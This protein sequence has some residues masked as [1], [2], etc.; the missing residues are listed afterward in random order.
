MILTSL[1]VLSSPLVLPL[2]QAVAGTLTTLV[3]FN[4]VNGAS[5]K[6]GVLQGTDSNIYGTTSEGGSQNRGTAFKLTGTN[7]STLT[8]LVNF[9]G[10]NGTNPIARLFQ[11]SDGNLYG[12]TSTGGTSNLGT[13]FRLAKTTF[14]TLTTLSNFNGTNGANPAGRLISGSDGRLWGT[15]SAGGVNGRGT[16]FKVPLTGGTP[17]IVVNFNGTNGATPL[18]RLQLA[19]DGNYY[20][21]TS[22]GGTSNRGT[23]FKLTPAGVL[24][25]YSFNGSNGQSPQSALIESSGFLYGTTFLGGASNRGAIF[26]VP[27]GGGS[28]VLV[29]S[30]N[31]TNGANPTAALIR[32]IDGNFYGTASTGGASNKGSIYRLVGGTISLLFSFNGTNGA[33]P[34]STLIQ[35]SNGAFYGTA[36]AGGTS[37]RGTVFRYVN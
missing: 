18:A 17:T 26:R 27:L 23:V 28:P 3:N 15:T 25:S 11:A 12:V 31:G 29:A 6:A 1:A 16:V 32:G 10:T 9:N 13:V 24:T 8:T 30:F 35:L 36:S 20:G 34:N 33:T 7:F 5:P 22:T 4:G 21:T 14:T 2:P 37:N 19:T